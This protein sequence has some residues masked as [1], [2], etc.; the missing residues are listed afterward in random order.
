MSKSEEQ[1]AL[2]DLMD[3][4]KVEIREYK[5]AWCTVP[6]HLYKQLFA[7]ADRLYEL[8]QEDEWR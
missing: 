8:R 2:R 7:A 1:E 3:D 4:L 5:R 6:N